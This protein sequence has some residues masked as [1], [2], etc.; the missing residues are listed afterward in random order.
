MGFLR[1]PANAAGIPPGRPAA[2]AS[3]A[4]GRSAREEL[5]EENV[6]RILRFFIY[7]FG[8]KWAITTTGLTLEEVKRRA[9]SSQLA[10]QLLLFGHNKNGFARAKCVNRKA[11]FFFGSIALCCCRPLGVTGVL[12]KLLLGFSVS[13]LFAQNKGTQAA[14]KD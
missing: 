5:V 3:A 9:A 1:R 11:S 7:F 13:N 4:R 10:S 2:E 14:Q 6:V 8:P 12:L